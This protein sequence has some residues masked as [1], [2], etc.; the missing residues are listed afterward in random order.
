M[1]AVLKQ[2][3]LERLDA[4]ED[5]DGAWV[6]LVLA[7]CEGREDLEKTLGG[8]LLRKRPR[9]RVPPRVAGE[10]PGAYLRSITVE[11]FRGIGPA[12]TLTLT[13]GPG[14]T[15]V[16]GRNGSGK[17]SFAEA[18]EF[19][20]TGRT[21]RWEGRAG[22]VLRDGWRNLHHGTAAI[23]AEFE[24]EGEGASTVTRAWRAD[25]ELEASVATWQPHGKPRKP[26]ASLGWD[27]ALSVYR[28]FLPYSELGDLLTDKPHALHDA[29]STVLGLE[30]LDAAQELLREARLQRERRYRD[31]A[32]ALGPLLDRLDQLVREADDGRARECHAAL[33]GRKWDLPRAA[34]VVEGGGDA[35]DPLVSLLRQ[36][37]GLVPPP[38]A[39]VELAAKELEAALREVARTRATDAG[40]AREL[41]ALL[42]QALT[43]HDHTG[44]GPCP[45]CGTREQLDAAWRERTEGEIARL[46]A[47]ASAADRAHAR[48]AQATRA[49]EQL[50]AAPPAVLTRLAAEGVTD[51]REAL[52]A[53][54]RWRDGIERSSPA[55]LATHLREAYDP[56]NEA[57]AAL[58]ESVSRELKRRD[59]R[60]LPLAA[61]VREW[62]TTA[63]DAVRGKEQ[64]ADLK[65]AEAWFKETQAALRAERFAPIA[66]Q[67]KAI[68][69]TLRQNSNVELESIALEGS[70]TRRRV[71]LDV[72][73]D[74]VEG[75]A[76]G[77]MSQGE[78]NAL[79]L[80]LFMPRASLPQSPFRFMVI[81]DPVQSMDP[82]RV[83]GLARALHQASRTRQVIVFTHDERLPDAVRHLGLPARVIQVTRRPGSIVET[84]P[85]LTPVE[86]YLKDAHDLVRTN[87]L[88]EH[89]KRRVV[90]GFCRSAIEAACADLVRSRRLRRGEPHVDV[91]RLIER[92]KRLNA[93]MG[94]ALFDEEQREAEV[95]RSIDNRFGKPAVD[96]FK[97]C[98]DGAHGN[99][100]GDLD[101]LVADTRRLTQ[102]VLALS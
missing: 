4:D 51:A 24:V 101:A 78:L 99:F 85:A 58:G 12:S 57:L 68:W 22:N 62:L 50:L 15:L 37:Q 17:S 63:Q 56:L 3:V 48:L 87:E 91:E 41:I 8:D 59:D 60:W 54:Q 20:L 74:G 72:T 29:L 36:G 84:R 89:V 42:Q 71:A 96:A 9:S 52:D 75:A 90:P 39:Q 100:D 102:Q 93:L 30:D 83:D 10:P 95:L 33:S 6:W 45:V 25:A 38:R 73:V 5:A 86:G 67:A 14:L 94:L 31:V 7:A 55:A 2:L 11:G 16:V 18:L 35:A 79:A 26:L 97:A 76:L 47:E 46:R 80:C 65:K 19:L 92:Q 21:R 88:P 64:L 61:D 66:E 40:R 27:E 81:D 98:N 70:A 23:S 32:A 34:A 13:P 44:D 82:A 69:Q 1:D 49:A 43:V 53:W 77:V 28:P